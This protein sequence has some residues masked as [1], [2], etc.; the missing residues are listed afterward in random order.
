[1]WML[2]LPLHQ[3]LARL[4]LRNGNHLHLFAFIQVLNR[5]ELHL[6]RYPMV[7]IIVHEYRVGSDLTQIGP[8]SAGVTRLFAQFPLGSLPVFLSRVDDASGQFQR[9]FPSTK[10]ILPDE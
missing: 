2:E 5:V 1:M 8:L 4:V 9:I 10:T 3:P 7:N 6:L